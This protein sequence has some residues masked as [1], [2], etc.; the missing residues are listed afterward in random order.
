MR[1]IFKILFYFLVDKSLV[2][3]TNATLTHLYFSSTSPKRRPTQAPVMKIRIMIKLLQ[4]STLRNLPTQTIVTHIQ[5]LQTCSRQ[6]FRQISINLIMIHIKIR[7]ARWKLHIRH[8]K[9]ELIPRKISYLNCLVCP[10]KH[11]EI[12]RQL[13]SRKIYNREV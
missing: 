6:R 11:S 1:L 7:Q 12:T 2:F 5:E 10:K 13:V 4:V 9:P 8:I 3:T